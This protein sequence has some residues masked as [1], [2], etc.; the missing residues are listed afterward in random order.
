MNI[1]KIRVLSPSVANKI[2]A[3]EVVE[4]PASVI[5]ELVENSIDAGA[6]FITVEIADGGLSYMRVSDNGIG[7]NEEDAK[8]CFLRHA[9]SKIHDTEDLF[10]IS[11]L[12]FRGEAM[13]SIAAVS[14][15]TLKTHRIGE[16]FGTMINIDAGS[17]RRVE[18]CGCPDGTT[19]EVS[20]LFFNVPARLKFMKAAKTEANYVSD[21]VLRMI[22]AHP[23]ISIKFIN[24]STLI[25]HSNGDGSLKN[26]IYNVYG[27]EIIPYLRNMNYKDDYLSISGYIASEHLSKPNRTHQSFFVNGRYIRSL[28]LSSSLQNAYD[29][30]VMTGRFPVAVLNFDIAYDLVDVNVHPNKLEIKFADEQRVSAT[31]YNA[32]KSALGASS[33][34]VYVPANADTADDTKATDINPEQPSPAEEKRLFDILMSQANITAASESEAV[35][36]AAYIE[37]NTAAVAQEAVDEPHSKQ[38]DS[39]TA[40]EL[41]LPFFPAPAPK[42]DDDDATDQKQAAN[43]QVQ[44]DVSPYEV[45]GCVFDSFW[46]IC[47]N[48]NL[49]L[50]D[51]HA[52]HERMLYEEAINGNI[53]AHSQ[54]LLLPFT[55]KLTTEEYNTYTDNK[56]L[57]EEFGFQIEPFGTHTLR[58]TAVPH[59]LSEAED[60]RFFRDTL[61][62][63][64]KK[65]SVTLT[66]MK[67]E[68]LIR[69]SCKAAIKLGN[70]VPKRMIEAILDEY[71][72]SGIPLTCPHGRP[73]MIAITKKDMFKQF[74]RIN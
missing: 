50:L 73:V 4:R 56:A 40:N 18:P 63:L 45:L 10:S 23:E 55:V 37:N 8:N 15:V 20:D 3:G 48:E 9:T 72:K 12:G 13:A 11:T 44:F 21:F 41:E 52:A 28:K 1:N 33:I 7:M 6:T 58:I 64:S 67:R 27:A 66:D 47:Q 59:I 25:Y 26:A 30:R 74:K 35:S 17:F 42:S 5:K 68:V 29:T 36:E 62:Q 69:A 31:L 51:Q 65:K 22:L 32:A 53:K 38:A 2:A 71:A 54:M 34:P 46:L 39:G 14:R 24:N 19:V 57:F 60:D 61:E 16:N 70:A 49:F 43:T